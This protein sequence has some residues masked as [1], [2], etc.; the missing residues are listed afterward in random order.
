MAMIDWANDYVS[1]DYVQRGWLK[2]TARV[3][4]FAAI[5]PFKSLQH[6]EGQS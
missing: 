4:T 2:V 1:L 6:Y 5:Q 3:L